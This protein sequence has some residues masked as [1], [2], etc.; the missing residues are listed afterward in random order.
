MSLVETIHT[1]NWIL[2]DISPDNFLVASQGKNDEIE[3]H[4]VDFGMAKQYWDPKTEKH[5]P[6]RKNK[7]SGTT[8]YMSINTHRGLKQSRRDDM[9]AMG[10]VF[11]YFL[12]G[13]LPWQGIS[14]AD[15]EEKCQ[16]IG[17][18]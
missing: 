14:A 9:E 18:K 12:R 4:V 5:I 2:G 11:I 16:R 13:A 17:K 15:E 10:Y 6:D 7:S 1:K 3:I 8:R